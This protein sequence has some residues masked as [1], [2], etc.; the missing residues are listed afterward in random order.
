M[1]T[2]I[3]VL[4]HGSKKGARKTFIQIVF[5]VSGQ[6]DLAKEEAT[7]LRR[8]EDGIVEIKEDLEAESGLTRSFPAD[9]KSSAELTKTDL[10]KL[11][12]LERQ[13]EEEEDDEDEDEEENERERIP[14]LAKSPADL[15]GI[16]EEREKAQAKK[17]HSHCVRRKRGRKW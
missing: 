14:P 12:E 2:R 15:Y 3:C 13:E 8:N 4:P 9:M 11:R 6:I 16:M 7:G 1:L 17:Y 10:M 5:L